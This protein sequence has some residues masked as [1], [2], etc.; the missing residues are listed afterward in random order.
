MTLQI[1]EGI[2]SPVQ[3]VSIIHIMC[4][5][6]SGQTGDDKRVAGLFM[7]PDENL[8]FLCLCFFF[9]CVQRCGAG[10]DC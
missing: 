10:G 4:K 6:E 1:K 5:R 8:S 9:L 7:Y 3:F 2:R